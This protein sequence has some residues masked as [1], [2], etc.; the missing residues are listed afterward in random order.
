LLKD[1]LH[2]I[3]PGHIDTNQSADQN[4]NRRIRTKS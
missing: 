2:W 1:R 4:D 3:R